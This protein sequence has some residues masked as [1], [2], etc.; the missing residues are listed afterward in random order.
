MRTPGTD[1]DLVRGFL[2]NERII[3]EINHIKKIESVG[4]KC[5][6]I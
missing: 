4:E 5:W 1:D 2:F 6:S 3:E